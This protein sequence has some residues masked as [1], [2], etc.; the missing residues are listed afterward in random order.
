MC[1]YEFDENEMAY[2][3]LQGKVSENCFVKSCDPINLLVCNTCMDGIKEYMMAE[4]CKDKKR[5]T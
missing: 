1:G 5:E 4:F 3:C 2:L